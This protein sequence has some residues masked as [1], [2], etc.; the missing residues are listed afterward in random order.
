VTVELTYGLE[1]I[2]MYLQDVDSVYDL[3]WG[4][5]VSYGQ[6]HHRDEVEFSR[7]N[8]ELA[9]VPSL[10]SRFGDYE[11]E[12]G[13]LCDA[14]AVLPAYDYCM[15]ASHTFNLL[16]ARRAISVTERA[17]YIQRVRSLAKRCA[18]GYVALREQLGHPLLKRG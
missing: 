16:D 9:D 12:C 17:R 1:R 18:E 2:C 11:A 14:G 8:F 15:K 10:L 4:A 6:V 7:H 5:G 3:H 13:R